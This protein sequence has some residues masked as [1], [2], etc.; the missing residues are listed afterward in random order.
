MM[1]IFGHPMS[2]CTRKV[3]MTLGE[4]K[5]PH[6]FVTVDFATGEH[7]KPAHLAH[8]PFG[9]VPAMEDDGFGLYE[10]RAICKYINEKVG[11]HLVPKDLRGH[12]LV[13]QWASV[14]T[15]NF[16]PHAMKFIYHDVFKRPQ[17]EAT[18]EAAKQGVEKALGVMEATLAKTPY[19]AGKE[20]SLADI[21]F[22]PYVE[23][24][25]VTPLKETFARYPHTSAWWTRVSERPT[26]L[27]VAGR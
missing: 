4:T 6:E 16:T 10:S 26:W 22:M 1:K 3:L 14:E 19:L 21:F 15:S 20:L 25:M 2:T 11:G 7:K 9:Q 8:Q 12:A 5:T 13:E 17:D 23:Y 24:G 18:L 27:K